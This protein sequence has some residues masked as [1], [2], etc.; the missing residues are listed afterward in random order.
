MK[1]SSCWPYSRRRSR[2]AWWP[3][4]LDLGA[5]GLQ[6]ALVVGG[7]RDIA[8][9]PV[10][11]VAVGQLRLPLDHALTGPAPTGAAQEPGPAAQLLVGH[12]GRAGR[13]DLPD[14]LLRSDRSH[15]QR[16]ASAVRRRGAAAPGNR[17]RPRLAAIRRSNRWRAR[18]RRS[19]NSTSRPGWRGPGP[20]AAER[21][22]PGPDGRRGDRAQLGPSV[23][24]QAERN[25][26]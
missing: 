22:R 24:A 17:R 1:A 11:G 6:I 15:G 20:L 13:L 9:K 16:L 26:A 2:W 19:G 12:L 18:R 21:P 10:L 25:T 5:G 23:D 4:L 14:G 3:S 8:G 7:D